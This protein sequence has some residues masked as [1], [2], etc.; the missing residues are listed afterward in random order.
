MGAAREEAVSRLQNALNEYVIEGIKTTI[1]F[2]LEILGDEYFRKGK[3][4]TGFVHE[5]IGSLAVEEEHEGEEVAALSAVLAAYLR[6]RRE[7][8]AVIPRR[9][10]QRASTWKHPRVGW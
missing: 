4:H 7:G 1:P 9:T 6:Y 10:P 8:L 3:I 5:R 2:Q